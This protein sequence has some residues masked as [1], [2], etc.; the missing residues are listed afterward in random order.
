MSLL[1]DSPYVLKVPT[2]W[3]CLKWTPDKLAEIFNEENI[4]GRTA[5]TSREILDEKSCRSIFQP[6]KKFLEM[7]E[8]WYCAYL[9]MTELRIEQVKWEDVGL[10][11][12]GGDACLWIGSNGSGTQLH[13]DAYG[14]GFYSILHR[15][16]VWQGNFPKNMCFNS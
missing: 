6:L 4:S 10:R 2:H 7:D 9:R 12:S 16:S 14:K 1:R 5:R 3:N 13:Q 8:V 15:K 11:D